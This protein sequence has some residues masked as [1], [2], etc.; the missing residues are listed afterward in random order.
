M[1]VFTLGVVVLLSLRHSFFYL[2]AAL[3]LGFGNA[4]SRVARSAL[5]LHLVPNALMGRIT[6]FYHLLDRL[7]RT[8]LV[9]AM[10]IIDFYGPPS[11]FA[12]LLGLM[13]FSIWGALATRRS[14]HASEAELTATAAPV[15]AGQT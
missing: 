2:T 8:I 15:P 10:A 5:M 6:V 13:V 11:G 1:I 7:L 14:I 3:L 9:A 12:V 4:G